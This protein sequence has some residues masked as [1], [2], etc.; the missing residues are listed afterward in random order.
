[1][2]MQILVSKY[3]YSLKGA[4]LWRMA[5]DLGQEKYNMSLEHLT[6]C[7]ISKKALKD[8]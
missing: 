2:Q 1:M 3:H 6:H 4:V 7:M 5:P 8:K